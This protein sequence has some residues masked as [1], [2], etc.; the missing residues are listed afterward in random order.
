MLNTTLQPMI[1]AAARTTPLV[2]YT[3]LTACLTYAEAVAR[4]EAPQALINDVRIYPDVVAPAKHIGVA[5]IKRRVRKLQVSIKGVAT[6]DALRMCL[7]DSFEG[8]DDWSKT[9]DRLT[10]AHYLAS[11]AMELEEVLLA[12]DLPY[13]VELE[14]AQLIACLTDHVTIMV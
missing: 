8:F 10:A 13:E 2:S 9:T 7:V 4:L 5:A 3:A 11:F 6:A 1:G 14:L 12:S